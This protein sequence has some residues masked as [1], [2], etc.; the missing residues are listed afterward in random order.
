MLRASS[1]MLVQAYQDKLI[2]IGEALGYETRRSYKKSAAGDA[3]WLD[4]RGG[5]IWTESLPVV[6]F[7]LL[8]F[9]T[10]KE[11][12]EAIATLQAISPSLGVL[13]VIEEAYAERGRLLKRFDT[14]T[15][16]DH[17][18]QIARGLAE[19]IGL[20]F[21][22]DVWTDKEVNAL[23]QKEVEGRLRFA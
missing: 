23:Y 19:G 5:R 2:E 7:K 3:V 18:R 9:E 15:Y 14:E 13:V 4:R 11:I 10:T 21:R 16:P 12:R 1:Q 8:T 17:I 6:A 20:A 22:V